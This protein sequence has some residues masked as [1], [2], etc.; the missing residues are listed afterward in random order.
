M[1]HAASSCAAERKESMK[2]PPKRDRIVRYLATW[3]GTLNPG[4][5]IPINSPLILT[6]DCVTKE[7]VLRAS[8]MAWKEES[9]VREA[10]APFRLNL[11]PLGLDFDSEF[12]RTALDNLIFD[13]IRI[14]E[15][16]LKFDSAIDVVVFINKIAAALGHPPVLALEKH[17]IKREVLVKFLGDERRWVDEAYW[18]AVSAPLPQVMEIAQ[19]NVLMKALLKMRRESDGVRVTF[20]P[21]LDHET[22]TMLYGAHNTQ[23]VMSPEDCD[24]VLAIG[25]PG[26]VPQR[27]TLTFWFR[28]IVPGASGVTNALVPHIDRVELV[29]SEKKGS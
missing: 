17:T 29:S 5:Q 9:L 1:N 24:K 10:L 20:R 22:A 3:S 6:H 2:Y 13:I 4:S 21:T 27:I 18:L 7:A 8:I 28:R 16:K 11:A 25:K 23:F 14:G 15:T 12:R 26:Y 19:E